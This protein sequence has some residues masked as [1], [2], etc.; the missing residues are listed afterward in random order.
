V[1][2]L[3]S[4]G[5]MWLRRLAGVEVPERFLVQHGRQ[6]ADRLDVVVAGGGR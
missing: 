1:I 5:V 2:A 6:G 4:L 3:F